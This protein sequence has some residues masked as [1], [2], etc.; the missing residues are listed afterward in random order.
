MG[1]LRWVIRRCAATPP[2]PELRACAARTRSESWAVGGLRFSHRR[3]GRECD[4]EGTWLAENGHR[5]QVHRG[6]AV[7]SLQ[8]PFGLV[9]EPDVHAVLA[10]AT[11]DAARSASRGERSSAGS[12]TNAA[13]A[14]A[15]LEDDSGFSAVH[16]AI[17]FPSRTGPSSD[18]RACFDVLAWIVRSECPCLAA[19]S[20]DWDAIV[21]PL[22]EPRR[23]D[24]RQTSSMR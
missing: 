8:T 23:E 4:F 9:T 21:A 2:A 5:R 1:L 12:P 18:P 15:V 22:R 11:T 24:R 7:V 6:E 13:T 14:L 3:A 17:A 20:I 16:S 10:S 19:R